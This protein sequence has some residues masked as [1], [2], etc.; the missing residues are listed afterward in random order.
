[1]WTPVANLVGG[2]A[3][4]HGTYVSEFLW[5]INNY[6]IWNV[7]LSM[8]ITVWLPLFLELIFCVSE[9]ITYIHSNAAVPHIH[10]CLFWWNEKHKISSIFQFQLQ[11]EVNF[12]WNKPIIF[13][14]ARW[15]SLT[16]V[17]ILYWQTMCCLSSWVINNVLHASINVVMELKNMIIT[18][19]ISSVPHTTVVPGA[20]KCTL[21][22][23]K[24]MCH[25]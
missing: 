16:V 3:V 2:S 24:S 17:V 1:M 19:C 15:W 6:S 23:W 18:L 21:L 13:V 11:L 10:S 4:K 12:Q 20:K 7:H 22:T 5:C 8:Y 14:V 9:H 25:S